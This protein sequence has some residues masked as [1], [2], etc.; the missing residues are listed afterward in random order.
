MRNSIKALAGVGIVALALTGCSSAGDPAGG[1]AGNGD[2]T[3]SLVLGHAGSTE[4]PRQ[5]AAEQFAERI[6]VAT[7]GRVTVEV[8]SDSTLGTW[9]EMIDGLQIGSTDIVIESMLSVEAYTDLASI[10][11]APFLYDSDEQFFEVWE[12]ELGQEIHG[13]VTEASGYALLGNMYRGS[14]ELTTKDPVTSLADVEGL[15]IR[16][17]SAQTMMDTWNALG[18]RAEA[19]PFN[20]VYSA[21]ESGVLD[22]QENPLDAILFN[23]IHEVAPNVTMSD[24]MYANYH[25]L[26]WDEALQGY[27]EDIRTAIQE[28]SAEVGQ[29]YTENTVTN[30]E[31]YRT[32]LEEG[33]AVFHELEDREAWIDA[34]QPVVEGLPDQVQTWVEQIRTM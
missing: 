19:L 6:E 4:D 31:D 33:G 23:S 17:P 28:V 16:T 10:E 30:L 15:T 27:P 11:T 26:M 9:E 32:Q 21:L 22:G 29:E 20:E 24:H 2:G 5:W 25:F 1:D 13:A 3:Y 7:D 18:A 12:G 34:T 14:R 8:H